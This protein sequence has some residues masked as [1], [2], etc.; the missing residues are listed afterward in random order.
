M[1]ITQRALEIGP[2]DLLGLTIHPTIHWYGLII[3]IGILLATSIVA[4]LTKRDGDD[5]D[6]VWDGVIWV[7]LIAVLGARLWSVIF[8]AGNAG[9]GRELSL[10]YLLDLNDGPLA[11]W[12]GGL[13]IFGA[14][15][16]GAIGVIWVAR[17]KKL[18]IPDWIDRAVI[19]V[20]VGQA[21][22]RWGNYV[23][24]ELYGRPTKLPWGIKIDYPEAPY[25]SADRFHPLFLYESLWSLALFGFLFYLYTRRRE[26]FQRWDFF[27]MYLMGYSVVRFLLEFIRVEI[28][29]VGQLNVS[30]VVTGV[31]FM[32]AL[33]ILLMRHCFGKLMAAVYPPFGKLV[34]NKTPASQP[35]KSKQA[36]SKA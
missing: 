26:K 21:I 3:V 9:Q 20:P 24:Q 28:P 30:Q 8:P 36:E 32:V 25:T 7:V 6:I 1:E 13:S 17:R 19:T 18:F 2:F 31:T 35:Q 29:K 15:L 34:E 12:S 16:G 22:G 14:V 27:L 33:W 23:N 10:D 11:I 5:P 4:W